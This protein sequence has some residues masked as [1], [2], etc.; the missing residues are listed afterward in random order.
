MI[1]R[2]LSPN[3]KE[4]EISS[5]RL[6]Y[7][8]LSKSDF[9]KEIGEPNFKTGTVLKIT[10]LRSSWGDK[11]LKKLTSELEKFVSAPDSEFK[12]FLTIND[13]KEKQIKK[14]CF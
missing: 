7:E 3:L 5:I 13:A 14:Q 2:Y 1:G 12:I 11:K 6:E 4:A 9:L 10:D 8:V